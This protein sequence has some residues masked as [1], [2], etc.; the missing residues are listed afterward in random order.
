MAL[1][2][3]IMAAC[4]APLSKIN[5]IQTTVKDDSIYN[6]TVYYPKSWYHSTI[7]A[8]SDTNGDKIIIVKIVC[9]PVRYS[10]ANNQIEYTTSFDIAVTYDEPV[11]ISTDQ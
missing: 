4:I 2:K 6:S 5:A 10:P 1:T 7:G 8:G 11:T 9:Y 3:K